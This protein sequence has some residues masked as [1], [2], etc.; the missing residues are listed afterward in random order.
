VSSTLA[1]LRSVQTMGYLNYD[2]QNKAYFPS[3]R[4]S[5]LGQWIHN[6]L[7]QGGV[8]VKMMEHLAALTQETVLLGIQNGLQSQHI[9]IVHTSQPLRY[10]PSVGTL[11][12][13][14]RSAVGRV[15]LGH[16]PRPAVRRIIE[17]INALG[18]DEGRTFD[19]K[20]VFDD[21][22]AVR[23]KG[24]AFSANLFTSGAAIVA[25]ALPPRA[26]DLPMAISVGGPANRIDEKRI[27]VLLEQIHS[28]IS[29]FLT[30]PSHESAT[31]IEN[32]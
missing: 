8:I 9:H 11:R 19:P 7:L 22:D 24:Y 28:V 10:Q 14:L 4:F 17:R 1:L 26:G 29:E 12:P 27:P 5:M 31:R 3:I 32:Q 6:Q 2:Y 20:D 15:L 16:Q 25:V 30:T 18:I 21:L 13:L 23:S